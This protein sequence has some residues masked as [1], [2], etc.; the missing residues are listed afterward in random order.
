MSKIRYIKKINMQLNYIILLHEVVNYDDEIE[1]Y[2]NLK[3]NKITKI[4]FI[5][6]LF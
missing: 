2:N 3:K 6:S 1:E 5:I 4:C